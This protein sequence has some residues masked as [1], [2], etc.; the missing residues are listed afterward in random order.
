MLLGIGQGTFP[1]HVEL[2]IASTWL[3][4]AP[5]HNEAMNPHAANMKW[6][7]RQRNPEDA[8]TTNTSRIGIMRRVS[9]T[10]QRQMQ[11]K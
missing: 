6:A 5:P 9:N 8:R 10:Y 1:P 7:T 3:V 4:G 2:T 11:T